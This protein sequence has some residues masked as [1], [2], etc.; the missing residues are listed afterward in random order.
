MPLSVRRQAFQAVIGLIAGING[1][2]PY[3]STVDEVQNSDLAPS[4]DVVDDVVVGVFPR[5][6]RVDSTKTR[7]TH[8]QDSNARLMIGIRAIMRVAVDNA[9]DQKDQLIDDVR[10]A[11]FSSLNLG[12]QS[13][14]FRIEDFAT[15]QESVQPNGTVGAFAQFLATLTVAWL[16]DPSNPSGQ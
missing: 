4:D 11:L 14:A 10:R 5:L 15:E 6:F 3:T 8:G 9:V 7:L 13:N 1:Q 2:D 16:E 12:I